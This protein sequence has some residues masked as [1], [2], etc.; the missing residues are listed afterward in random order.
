MLSSHVF[1]EARTSRISVHCVNVG[2]QRGHC[3]QC[4]LF[5]RNSCMAHSA[6][7]SITYACLLR[8]HYDT[9]TYKLTQVVQAVLASH[10]LHPNQLITANLAEVQRVGEQIQTETTKAADQSQKLTQKSGR[11]LEGLVDP[12]LVRIKLAAPIT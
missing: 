12:P 10:K 6:C 2:G 5:R 4:C 9:H 3:L 1:C 7:T 8:H 11:K